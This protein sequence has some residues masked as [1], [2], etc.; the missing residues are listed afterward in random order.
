MKENHKD[1]R[2]RY[3]FIINRMKFWKVFL[4]Y[5]SLSKSMIVI[6]NIKKENNNKKISYSIAFSEDYAEM[7]CNYIWLHNSKEIKNCFGMGFSLSI[8]WM[9]FHTFLLFLAVATITGCNFKYV[10]KI[11]LIGLT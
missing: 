1:E 5:P 2:N 9:S 6:L 4:K 3:I 10:T 11:V 8:T 7:F